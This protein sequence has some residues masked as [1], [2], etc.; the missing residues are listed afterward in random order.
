MI[1]LIERAKSLPSGVS[2][3][4]CRLP[5]LGSSSFVINPRPL[6]SRPI[7]PVDRRSVLRLD[8]AVVRPSSCSSACLLQP[9]CEAMYKKTLT[10]CP[11]ISRSLIRI[12]SKARWIF[13]IRAS[14]ACV[15]IGFTVLGCCA[16]PL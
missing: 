13:S 1:C 3:N 4:T 7:R 2:F 15:L 16:P 6:V 9:S 14:V 12:K 10:T 8:E 11:G 5:L